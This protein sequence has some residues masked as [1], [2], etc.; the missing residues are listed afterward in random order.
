[1]P[2]MMQ[3]QQ[4]ESEGEQLERLNRLRK[5]QATKRMEQLIKLHADNLELAERSHD[6]GDETSQQHVSQP[7]NTAAVRN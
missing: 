1:M 6:A 7:H 4:E 5:K 3:E 2:S